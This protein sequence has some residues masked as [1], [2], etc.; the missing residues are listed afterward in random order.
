MFLVRRSS[1]TGHGCNPTQP[2]YW[3]KLTDMLRTLMNQKVKVDEKWIS[4]TSDDG[5]RA[6]RAEWPTLVCP[7]YSV[8]KKDGAPS[9]CRLWLASQ[10]HFKDAYLLPMI[11]DILHVL[12]GKQWFS[13]V[14]SASNYWHVSLP[15][16]ARKKTTFVTQSWLFQF[17]L[18]PFDVCNAP[19]NFERLC[20]M[21][22]DGR[23]A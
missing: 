19:A 12:A 18:V 22:S 7:G 23:D 3:W 21:V 17:K 14:D 1:L 16:D 6:N 4:E 5:W 13:T 8:A 15:D 11:D 20:Y 10:N 2:I 9:L